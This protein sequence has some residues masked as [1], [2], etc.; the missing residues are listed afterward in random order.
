VEHVERQDERERELRD[1]ADALEQQGD[2][3]EQSGGELEQQINET[4]ED[5]ERAR[6]SSEVPGAQD[7]EEGAPAVTETHDESDAD[8]RPGTSETPGAADDEGQST[9][10]PPNDDAP[11]SDDED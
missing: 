7:P 3:L 2:Q 8:A 5:W 10:N 4:R 1:D 6:D 11:A 9:G